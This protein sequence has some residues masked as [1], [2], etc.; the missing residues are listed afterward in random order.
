MAGLSLHTEQRLDAFWSREIGCA[1]G[2]LALKGRLAISLPSKDGSEFVRVFRR[3]NAEIITCSPSLYS[4]I[5]TAAGRPSRS[6]DDS[7]FVMETLGGALE[8]LVGPV[9]LG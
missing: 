7:V 8:R 4:R 9:F 5:A 1:Q 2:D 6:P 3:R